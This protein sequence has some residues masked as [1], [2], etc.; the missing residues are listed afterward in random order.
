MGPKPFNG[1]QMTVK[2]NSAVFGD[3]K[4]TEQCTSISPCGYQMYVICY[5]PL[6]SREEFRNHAIL[7]EDV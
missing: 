5:C 6:L 1:K 2:I 3:H 4:V 7:K